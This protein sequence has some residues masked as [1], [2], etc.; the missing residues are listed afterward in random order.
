MPMAPQ[1]DS[2]TVI[3]TMRR[4]KLDVSYCSFQHHCVNKHD[5]FGPTKDQNKQSKKIL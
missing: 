1:K 5:F 3:G 4:N 2:A